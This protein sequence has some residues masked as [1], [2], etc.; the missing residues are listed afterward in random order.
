MDSVTDPATC[1]LSSDLVPRFRR[2][3]PMPDEL[4]T[5]G[6]VNSRRRRIS[7]GDGAPITS[8]PSAFSTH[9]RR[10]SAAILL[11]RNH[12]MASSA[13][14]SI[15]DA[16]STGGGIIQAFSTTVMEA[17]LGARI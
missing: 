16:N 4:E 12:Q 13:A 1:T 5:L 3:M 10:R 11:S 2:Y 6:S 17:G 8:S 9:I 14:A 15:T 7:A